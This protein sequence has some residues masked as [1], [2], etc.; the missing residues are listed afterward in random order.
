LSITRI[1]SPLAKALW[2]A[3]KS[4]GSASPRVCHQEVALQFGFNRGRHMVMIGDRHA[5]ISAPFSKRR[6]LATIGLDFVLR[7]LRLAGKRRR[8]HTLEAA[9]RLHA[10]EAGDARLVEALLQA[11][12]VG[13]VGEIVVPPGDGRNSEFGLP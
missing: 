2:P 13:E 9:A 5:L 12:V 8:A 1:T 3:S 6:Y 10:R 7:E 4:S 11:Y